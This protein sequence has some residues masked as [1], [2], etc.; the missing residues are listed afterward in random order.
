MLMALEI[1]PTIS[2]EHI[3]GGSIKYEHGT[4]PSIEA[5]HGSRD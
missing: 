5:D 4:G 3:Q 2:G 1:A